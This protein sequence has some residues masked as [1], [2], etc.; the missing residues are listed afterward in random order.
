MQPFLLHAKESQG[1]VSALSRPE[2]ASSGRRYTIMKSRCTI[3]RAVSLDKRSDA[4]KHSHA[5]T[6]ALAVEATKA[7]HEPAPSGPLSRD[8]EARAVGSRPARLSE[9]D[10]ER[11]SKVCRSA[12][13]DVWSRCLQY[14]MCYY[15]FLTS[16][17]MGRLCWASSSSVSRRGIRAPATYPSSP[18]ETA[19]GWTVGTVDLTTAPGSSRA[20][21]SVAICC[22]PA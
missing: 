21:T 14:A 15:R 13:L 12:V 6:L 16:T 8:D 19:S 17:P 20:R 7:G 3:P 10:E 22:A 1:A 2:E 9:D 11:S 18:S 4:I 5:M